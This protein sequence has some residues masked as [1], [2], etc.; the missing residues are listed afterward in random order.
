M[1]KMC[2]IK[3]ADIHWTDLFILMHLMHSMK[4]HPMHSAL[5]RAA[6]FLA[7]NLCVKVNTCLQIVHKATNAHL[8]LTVW[9]VVVFKT[10]VTTFFYCFM[11]V[12]Q[13]QQQQHLTVCSNS[14][15]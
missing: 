2:F 9:L 4:T 1:G 13:Q 12:L 3:E 5:P 7:R 6:C 14:T 10:T 8:F 15:S 11:I